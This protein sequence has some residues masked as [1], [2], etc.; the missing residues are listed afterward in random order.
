M[1]KNSILKKLSLFS[2][3][4]FIDVILNKILFKRVLYMFQTK[5]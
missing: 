4:S 2:F 3:Y 1:K 5:K